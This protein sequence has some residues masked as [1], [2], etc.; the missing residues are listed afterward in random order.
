[1]KPSKQVTA[2]LLKEYLNGFKEQEVSRIEDAFNE[3]FSVFPNNAEADKAFIEHVEDMLDNWH[4][5][6][7]CGFSY[8]YDE[9]CEFH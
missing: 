9:P 5:C 1:M 2:K 7:V 3:K 8:S 6:D 4:P